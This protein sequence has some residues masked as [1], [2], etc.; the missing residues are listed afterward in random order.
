MRLWGLG[1]LVKSAAYILI[2]VVY[3]CRWCG[4]SEE[5]KSTA[6]VTIDEGSGAASEF[7]RQAYGSMPT[8]RD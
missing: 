7:E 3:G 6:E 8:S 1:N 4:A 5:L 2:A